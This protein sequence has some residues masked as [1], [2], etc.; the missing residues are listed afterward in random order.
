M[1]LV[2]KEEQLKVI[3]AGFGRTATESLQKALIIL[4]YPCY[5]MHVMHNN[6]SDNDIFVENLKKRE[7]ERDWNKL[8]K[9]RGYT[10]TVDWPT[11]AI[12][13]ELFKQN[14]SAKVILTVRDSP[15]Q[16][17]ESTRNSIYKLSQSRN[18]WQMRL[19]ALFDRHRANHKIVVDFVWDTFDGRF[20][21][22][23]C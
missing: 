22:M 17:Y 10:A 15:D 11:T 13:Q 23:G 5:H 4:G 6:P 1:S 19:L 21:D 14:P 12:Y 3:G 9:P 2:S 18:W 16:W 7:N 20:H 8:F